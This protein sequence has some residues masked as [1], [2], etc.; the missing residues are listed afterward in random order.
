MPRSSGWSSRTVDQSVDLLLTWVVDGVVRD[1]ITEGAQKPAAACH[2]L[3]GL[4]APPLVFGFGISQK[5]KVERLLGDRSKGRVGKSEQEPLE[6]DEREPKGIYTPANPGQRTRACKNVW[7]SPYLT[8]IMGA[9]SVSQF[10]LAQLGVH[11][12]YVWVH[13]LYSSENN[14]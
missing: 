2:L 9:C 14:C 12:I 6:W 11:A 8:V 10:W 1:C 7:I 3:P 4:P 13:D 5:Q